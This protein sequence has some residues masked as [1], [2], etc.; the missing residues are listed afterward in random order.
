LDRVRFTDH[1]VGNGEAL[2][3]RLE[4][5]NLEGMVTAGLSSNFPD[6]PNGSQKRTQLFR[7][8]LEVFK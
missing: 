4:A 6:Y 7:L 3:E 8:A 5:L 1:I 2:F